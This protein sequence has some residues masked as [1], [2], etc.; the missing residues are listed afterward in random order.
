MAI[1]MPLRNADC[2]PKFREWQMPITRRS[3]REMARITSSVSSGLQSLTK[4]ISKSMFSLVNVALSRS[5]MIGIAWL[6][7]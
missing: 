3:L 1:S 4:M 5:Y 7:L 2:E 6:S